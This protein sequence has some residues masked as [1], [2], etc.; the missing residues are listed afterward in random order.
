MPGAVAFEFEANQLLMLSRKIA[1]KMATS[2]KQATKSVHAD[3]ASQIQTGMVRTLEQRVRETRRNQRGSKHLEL[4]LMNPRNASVTNRGYGVLKED[5]MN[6]SPAALYWRRIEEGDQT[7]FS[8]YILFTNDMAGGKRYG[9][10]RPNGKR[11]RY[12]RQDGPVVVSDGAPPG[13]K[14]TRMPQHKGAYVQGIGPFPAYRFTE[15]GAAAF[16]SFPHYQRYEKALAAV[17]LKLEPFLR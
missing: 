16:R 17:G 5:Y 10:Y 4:A 8:G 1:S 7:T 9:P 3:A 12:T 2:F 13:Y 15:G 14:H 6:R 11:V